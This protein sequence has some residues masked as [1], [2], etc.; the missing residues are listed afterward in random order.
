MQAACR[1][2]ALASGPSCSSPSDVLRSTSAP[3]VR[4]ALLFHAAFAGLAAGALAL[5]APAL[6]WRLLALVVLYS[7]AL[8]LVGRVRGH[9]AWVRMWAFC[10]LVSLFQVLPDAF[11]A[12]VLG[13]LDFPPTGGPRLGPVPLA[14]AGMW[15]IPLWVALFAARSLTRDLRVRI[16]WAALVGGVL[17]VGAEATLWAVPIWRATGVATAGPVALYV[18]GPEVLLG[19]VACFAELW[20]RAWRAPVRVAAAAGVMLVYL[21]A[22]CVSYLLIEGGA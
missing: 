15:T 16:A 2:V 18:I 10:A 21:G 14:M 13:S 6:G 1:T 20:T 3:A 12:T 9:A 4:D 7:V 19:G 11:L 8:P 17:F 5:P 22:L